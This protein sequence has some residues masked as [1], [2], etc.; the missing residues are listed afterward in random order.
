MS[1]T[2]VSLGPTASTYALLE[3]TSIANVVTATAGAS[4][5]VGNIGISPG[6]TITGFPPGVC[7]GTLNRNTASSATA[8]SEFTSTYTT[9]RGIT[10]FV[11]T[12]PSA[13]GLNQILNPGTYSITNASL[14]GILILSGVGQYVFQV[15]GTLNTAATSTILLIGGALASQVFWAVT[16]NVTIGQGTT[17]VGTIITNSSTTTTVTAGQATQL[18]SNIAVGTAYTVAAGTA[19]AFTGSVVSL[20]SS[21]AMVFDTIVVSTTNPCYVKGTKILTKYGYKAIEDISVGEEI[22]VSGNLKDGDVVASAD[23]EK[24]TWG[25]SFN[26][27]NLNESNRPI[28]F[29]AGSLGNNMPFEDVRVSPNHGVIVNNKMVAAYDLINGSSI[30]QDM[31]CESLVYYHLETENHSVL[32]A[33][34]LLGESLCGCHEYFEPIAGCE[35]NLALEELNARLALECA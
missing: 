14:S 4:Y 23:C 5:I 8:L 19:S 27:F 21:G 34:G 24:V 15:N 35:H 32:N 20:S 11:S 13:M 33:S 25:G 18:G 17:F 10:A 6:S 26:V 28:V 7:T 30:Y 2:V 29:T 22:A 12:L 9:A 16:G 1:T 3:G 31:V